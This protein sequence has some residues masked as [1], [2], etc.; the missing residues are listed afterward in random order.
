MDGIFIG[1]GILFLIWGATDIIFPIAEIT[2]VA[3]FGLMRITLGTVSISIGIG[4]EAH[5]W[6]KIGNEKET[7]LENALR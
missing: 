4:V 7:R 2:K 3:V 1:M 5:A 6:A